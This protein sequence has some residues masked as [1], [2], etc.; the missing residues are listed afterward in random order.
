MK[1]AADVEAAVSAGADAIGF[2]FARSPRQ[3][4]PAAARALAEAIPDS[5]L[6]V[7]V[8]RDLPAERAAEVAAEAGVRAVQLHGDYPREAFAH[9][10][11]HR[12]IRATA[13]SRDTDIKVGAFGEHML[14]LDSAIPGS[15]ERWDLTGMDLPTGDWLLAGGL[16]PANVATAIAEAH[17]WGVDVSSGVEARRGVKDPAMIRDFVAAA[18]G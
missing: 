4:E 2:V 17:P 5:V 16:T 12:L 10:P 6:T 7:G 1:T 3:V 18:K 13:L 8:F 14:L 11:D 15:G 9:F